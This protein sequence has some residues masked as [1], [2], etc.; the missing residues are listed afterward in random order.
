VVVDTSAL[1]AI[2]FEER[3]GPWCAEQMAEAAGGD[4]VMS[5]VNLAETLILVAD[6]RPGALR[7]VEEQV[8]SSGAIRFVPP[9]AAQAQ[10]AA[11]ARL[12]FPLNLGDCF[13][14][15]LAV[16]E[17]APILTLDR[18]FLA[19]GHALLIPKPFPRRPRPRR[20]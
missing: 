17:D 18:D 6:R 9:D 16:A 7:A 15:A 12:R 13:A 4:V 1:L 11:A 8:V 10:A 14:Y 2:L 19:T 3:H 20:P 5:T